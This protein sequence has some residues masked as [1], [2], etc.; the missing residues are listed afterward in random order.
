MKRKVAFLLTAMLLISAAFTGCGGDKAAEPEGKTEIIIGMP[1]VIAEVAPTN[2]SNAWNLTT[3]GIA[4]YVYM[5]DESGKLYSRFVDSL[6]QVDDLNWEGK[7]KEGAVFSDGSPVDSKAICES[8]NKI[9][10]ENP[11]SNA[12]AGKIT[13]TVIDDATFK[14]T[15]ERATNV[16]Q[17]I[18]G[19]WSNIIFK[20][21]DDGSFVFTG[22]YMIESLTPKTELKLVPNPNY[23]ENAANRSPVTI[24]AFADSNALKLAFEAGEVDIAFPI[25]TDSKQ[26]LVDAGKTVKSIDAG[27][28][29]FA[30]MNM[31]G[32]PMTDIK[33]RQAVDLGIDRQ[34]YIDALKGGR[35]ATGI[36]AAYY[37]FAGNVQLV[38]DTDKAASL[39]DEAGWKLGSDGI[40]EK[41]GEKLSLRLA[42][43]PSRP[44]LSIIMQVM[45]SQLKELGIETTTAIHDDIGAVVSAGDYDIA[46]WAQHTAPTGEPAFFLNQFFRTDGAKNHNKLSDKRID[47]VL[48]NM[49]KEKSEAARYEMAK[50]IQNY[51]HE[52]LP[53]LYLVDPQWNMG[54]SDKVAN[55]Q[56]YCG[57]YYIVNAKLGL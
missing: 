2:G 14:A 56:P 33:V 34:N 4:E 28:Q 24:K 16:L 43:Y 40:R 7:V 20:T 1:W 5:L 12:S 39:L 47:G 48:D 26:A 52:D 8:M 50:E 31:L 25:A 10:T 6:T 29:Y 19:E 35:V 51:I 3:D 53:I 17:S 37:P 42:A 15:T 44:D 21:N 45:A 27:Y 18:L 22:P 9:Q 36:F 55:Y 11:L 38:K 32:G 49:G 23:D 57:D 46:F 54:V 30:F 13:F 41:N